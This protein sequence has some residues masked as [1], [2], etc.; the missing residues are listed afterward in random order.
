MSYSLKKR[1]TIIR[2]TI[3]YTAASY[4]FYFVLYSLNK[5]NSALNLEKLYLFMQD[6]ILL[7]SFAFLTL[8]I[9]YFGIRKSSTVLAIFNI[10]IAA[11]VLSLGLDKTQIIMTSFYVILSFIVYLLWEQELMSALFLPGY[12]S[13]YIY[14]KS[15]YN[16][17][18]TVSSPDGTFKGFL[19]NW[20]A[21]SCFIET[22]ALKVKGKELDIV[23]NFES[24]EFHFKGT[25][26]T[27]YGSGLGVVIKEK[28]EKDGSRLD[29]NQF[30]DI[31]SSRGYK[32]RF[33]G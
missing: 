26:T 31:I 11:K 5:G 17:P 30:Y 21:Q 29:W 14:S 4:F 32:N 33:N 19:T 28:T 12:K 15:E 22:E 1:T 10:I 2:N 3:L 24:L 13:N 9:Q 18:V 20:D 8:V 6:N 7:T 16:I 27:R 25:L 23:V